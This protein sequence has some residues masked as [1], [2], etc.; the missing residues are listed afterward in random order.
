V[1]IVVVVVHL[2]RKANKLLKKKPIMNS[3]NSTHSMRC[4]VL[5]NEY[6]FPLA[7]QKALLITAGRSHNTYCSG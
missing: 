7:S 3:V 2:Q 6:S 4:I 5:K 1:P